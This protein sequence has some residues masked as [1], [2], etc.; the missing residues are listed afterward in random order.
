MSYCS[1]CREKVRRTRSHADEGQAGIF[2]LSQ[3]TSAL[4]LALSLCFEAV[5]AASDPAPI[6]LQEAIELIEARGVT[7]IYSSNLVNPDMRV[8]ELPRGLEPR[9]QLEQILHPHG[10]A[11]N[12]GPNGMLLIVRAGPP[13]TTPQESTVAGNSSELE[14]VVV[15]ASRYSL[16]R[17]L[18]EVH[19]PKAVFVILQ[20]PGRT[21]MNGA[22]TFAR[23]FGHECGVIP[24]G[25]LCLR[26]SVPIGQSSPARHATFALFMRGSEGE[27]HGSTLIACPEQARASGQALV[28]W[29]IEPRIAV[30][31]IFVLPMNA[32]S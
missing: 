16:V 20:H 21:Q 30:Q 5:A 14:A 4:T 28:T 11:V 19:F 12:A 15:A 7:I 24:I 18:D 32:A 10:L 29:N 25:S 31:V 3:I 6:A 9:A 17:V 26:K 8:S 27:I 23:E 22:Q 1:T 2:V 13:T